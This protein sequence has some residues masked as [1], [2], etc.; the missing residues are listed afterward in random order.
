MP[1]SKA[2]AQ[3]STRLWPSCPMSCRIRTSFLRSAAPVTQT[4]C[5]SIQPFFFSSR[6]RHTRSLRDWSS[7]MCSS[8]LHGRWRLA[9][10]AKA[11][12]VTRQY[13]G[14]ALI[15]ETR[16]ETDQGSV[17]L[18][19]FMP[20][21]GGNSNMVR[22]VVGENGTVNMSMELAV[23]FGY[24]ARVPWIN[25][26]EDGTLRIIAGAD[27]VVLRTAVPVSVKDNCIVGD[28]AVQ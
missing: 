7:D 17:R 22:M 3:A 15:L 10:F 28:F 18:I 8:D 1:I 12:G 24:G 5:I 6:R 9:P 11:R 4:T 14:D 20:P 16:F 27:Q 26:Q 25:R 19:D 13:Q 23:R 2:R 21:R